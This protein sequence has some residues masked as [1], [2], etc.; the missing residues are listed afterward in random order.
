MVIFLVTFRLVFK[1]QGSHL[2]LAATLFYLFENQ[3]RSL[4]PA[5]LDHFILKTPSEYRTSSV[6]KWIK[7]VLKPNG[8]VFKWH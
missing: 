3:I 6:F 5:K 1:W 7:V 4:F 8:P 2:V